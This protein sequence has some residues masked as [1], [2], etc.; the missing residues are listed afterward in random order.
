M[1]LFLPSFT[2]QR[3]KRCHRCLC[4]FSIVLASKPQCFPQG[5]LSVCLFALAGLWKITWLAA[6]SSLTFRVLRTY[7]TIS[8]KKSQS[9]LFPKTP[10][11]SSW[12]VKSYWNQLSSCIYLNFLWISRWTQV[13]G[14]LNLKV[15]GRPMVIFHCVIL[16]LGWGTRGL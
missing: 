13:C 5:G 10:L 2:F 14:K 6:A 8:W 12:N 4:C 15:G 7:Q 1:L 3:K 9:L 11:V 16:K